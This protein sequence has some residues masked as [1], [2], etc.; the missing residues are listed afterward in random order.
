MEGNNFL[1]EEQLC[2]STYTLSK[3]FTKLYRPVL[4]PYSLTYTQ[5]VALL[6]LWEES[7]LSVQSLGTRLGL[8]S[9]TLT[10]MLKRMELNGFITRNRHPEDERKVILATTQKADD[11]KDELLRKVSAC[12]N[13]LNMNEK[14]YFDL[15]A[16][17]DDLSKTLG[18][19]LND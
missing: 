18:G 15:L 2:F 11:L 12:L 16:K 10:P 17:I 9:G 14:D 6:V 4:E 13:L 1:L 8:D 19:I 3:Q 5:Y 7:D